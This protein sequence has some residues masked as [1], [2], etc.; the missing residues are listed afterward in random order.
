MFSLQIRYVSELVLAID[1]S[2]SCRCLFWST[3]YSYVKVQAGEHKKPP[4]FIP[5]FEGV[6][7]MI[8]ERFSKKFCEQA[9]NGESL[10]EE[11][12]I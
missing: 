10:Q 3:D 7:A 9:A 6:R 12:S 2:A 11:R 8:F 4:T 1:A 5:F